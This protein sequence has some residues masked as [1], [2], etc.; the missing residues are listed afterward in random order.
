MTYK[1]TSVLTCLHYLR[2][3]SRTQ[4]FELDLV[5]PRK[6]TVRVGRSGGGR[7]GGSRN[8]TTRR[9]RDLDSVGSAQDL[10][11]VNVA[12]ILVDLRVVH[13]ENGAVNAICPRDIVTIVVL[14]HDVGGRAV[15][16]CPAKANTSTRHEIV[17]PRVNCVDVDYRELVGRYRLHSGNAVAN[18]TFLNGVTAS[19]R[20]SGDELSDKRDG[21]DGSNGFGEHHI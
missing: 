2:S 7:D 3:I 1:L 18:I 17:A 15:L 8:G 14:L 6:V 10:S 16:A 19:A 9:G 12:A 13:V 5:A 20:L 4:I 21:E 11:N